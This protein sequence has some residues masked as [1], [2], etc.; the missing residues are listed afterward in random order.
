LADW[1]KIS[2]EETL[3]KHGVSSEKGL[4]AKQVEE[5]RAKHG[6]NKFHEKKKEHILVQIFKHFKDLAI[7]ILVV[8]ALLGVALLIVDAVDPAQSVSV[9]TILKPVIIFAIIALN[10]GLAVVQE[11]GAEKAL[12][13]LA[14]LNSPQCYVLRDGS[15]IQIPTAEV[16][17]GDIVILKTG[18]LIPADCRIISSVDFLV[19]E[20]SLTGESEPIEKI[21]DIVEKVEGLGD[22]RNMVFSGCLVLGGN[23]TAIVCA[24]GMNTQIGK[25]AGYLNTTKKLKTPLQKRLTKLGRLITLVA[26][27]AAVVVLTIGFIQEGFTEINEHLFV[28]V[29]LAIAAVPEALVLIVTLILTHGVKKMV[30]RNALIRKLQAVETLGSTSVICSDKTGT[31]TMNQM[32][33]KRVWA[34][35]AD[36]VRDDELLDKHEEMLKKLLLV[37]NVSLET[38]KDGGEPVMVGDPTERS[39]M[40]LA[41]EKGIIKTE[42]DKEWERVNE[43]AF[44]SERKMMTTIVKKPDSSGYLVLTKGAFDRLPIKNKSDKLY[45]F[46]LND[47]HDK[48]A[49]DALRIIALA[50]KEIKELPKNIEDVESD[51]NFEGIIGIIDPP[52]PEAIVAIARAKEAGIRTVMITGDHA[53]TAK[54]IAKELGIIS[55]YKGAVMTGVELA[56]I[57]D[58]KLFEIVEDVCVYARVS[59]EDKIRIVQA[60]QR[61]GEVVAMTGDGVNDAPALKGADIG[62]AM[63]IAGTEVAKSASDMVLVDDKYSTIVDA[64]EEGRNV[65]SNIR[66]TIYFLLV[67]NFAEILI[68]LLG[69]SIFGAIPITA[70]MLLL[71]NVLFDGIPGLALAREKSDPRIMKRKPFDRKESF[72]SGGLVE[73]MIRQVA[74]FTVVS[75]IAYTLGTFWLS[76]VP[77][78]DTLR[79]SYSVRGLQSHTIGQSMTFLVLSWVAVMHVFTARSRMSIF[80][81]NPFK[82]NKRLA[83]SA[84]IMMMVAPLLMFI[85]GVNYA[86][87]LAYRCGDTGTITAAWELFG[88]YFWFICVGLALVPTLVA[89]YSKFWDNYKSNVNERNRIK[90]QHID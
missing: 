29:A 31:L 74:A 5:S 84:V 24:S 54:A 61:K 89:E 30:G 49:S 47:M 18:D 15:R 77:L 17:I 46:E 26:L 35:G 6:E 55:D 80:K 75:L 33:I 83:W 90:R 39:I 72:F 2:A 56:Q 11:R 4:S 78:A 37:S 69:R 86:I 60:W 38:P 50:S 10:I 45:S 70:L 53:V 76:G 27:A 44:S 7:I 36:P 42:L 41:I 28:A 66:K 23:A 19:D 71:I 68:M 43:I 9:G 16:V 88:W 34:Y 25:I 82:E 1:H 67:A 62:T 79:G 57:D 73:V 48:F 63:G 22:Q 8:G 64:V 13:A 21:S 20:A 87:G 32:S 14:V 65:F 12:D 52:R 40:R 58:D 59:P 85:P 51:L 81:N 3:K